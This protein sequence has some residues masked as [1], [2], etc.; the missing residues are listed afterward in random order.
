MLVGHFAIAFVSK[1]IEPRISL[2]TFV[3]AA[4]TPDILWP[5]FSIAGI[6]YTA[7]QSSDVTAP[8][9]ISYSH[10]LLMVAVWAALF[11]LS[12]LVFR[13]YSRG[14]WILFAAVLSHWVLDSISHRHSLLPGSHA[15]VG[16]SLWNSLPATLVVEGGF[17]SVAMIVY[18]RSTRANGLSGNYGFWPVVVVL[19]FIW[20]TNIKSGPP[21]PNAVI[22]SLIFF[23]LLVAWAYW[24]NRARSNKEAR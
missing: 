20:T 6:E 21:P 14:A 13:R 11:A 9:D 2:G 8:L 16:L 5:I 7:N 18:L 4:M 12:Y 3:L 23:S 1:S 22:G 10:S 15:Y 17:W 24:M 19:T